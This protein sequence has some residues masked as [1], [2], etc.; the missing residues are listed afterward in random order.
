[1]A[2]S[3]GSSSTEFGLDTGEEII[4]DEE[5]LLSQA[6][7]R[8]WFLAQLRGF[9][10][11]YHLFLALRLHGLL[12]K[13]ALRRALDRIVYR[14]ES[15]RT[16]FTQVDGRPV[17][18]I[19]D[20][21]YCA[22]RL[23]EEDW[24]GKD[25][26]PA[27][28]SRLMKRELQNGFDLERETLI[29][30]RLL[31]VD[32]E[33]H[34][35]LVTLHRLVAD[36]R[37]LSVFQQELGSLYGA[38]RANR[39]DPLPELGLQYADYA[40]WQ[41]QWMGE[42]ALRQQGEYWQA[43]L[44]GAPALLRLPSDHPRPAR[45][46]FAGGLV[47]LEFEPALTDRLR[48]FAQRG[49]IAPQMVLLAAWGALLS[50]LSGQEDLVIGTSVANRR[51][52]T[53]AMIGCFANPLALRIDLSGNPSGSSLVRRLAKHWTEAMLRQ[54]IPFEQV[55]DLLQ[56][57]RSLAHAPL[58]QVM[59]E[60]QDS[61]DEPP[62]LAG[63]R[64]ERCSG[65]L[66]RSVPFDLILRLRAEGARIVGDVAY[67]SALFEQH[68]IGHLVACLHELIGAMLSHPELPLGQLS[69]PMWE[70]H[71]YALR[72]AHRHVTE[73]ALATAGAKETNAGYESPQTPTETAIATIWSRLLQVEHISR[74]DD[75]F[76]LGGR[77]LQIVELVAQLQQ[78]HG[79]NARLEDVFVYPVLVDLAR[80]LEGSSRAML[81]PITRSERGQ[82]IPLS[83]A[84]QRLWFLAQMASGSEAYHVAMGMRL[85]GELDAVALR[86][87]LDRIVARH[88]SL[89]TTFVEV[90]GEPTQRI[91]PAEGSRFHLLEHDLQGDTH[92]KEKV[93][94]LTA[95]EALTPFDLARG[96]LVRGRL[97]KLQE[98]NHILR[99]TMHH[100][101]S[102]GWS[103]GVLRKEFTALYTAFRHG[104]PDPLPALPIQ[105]ADF[106][107]WQRKWM[108]GDVLRRQ[109]EYW[110]TT[111]IG[112]PALL[113]LPADHPRP[114]LQ[115]YRGAVAQL[116]LDE[117]LSAQLKALSRRHGATLFM[118]VLAGLSALFARLSGQHDIV[119]GVPVANRVR[120]ETEGLIGFFA[121]NLA[122]RLNLSGSPSVSELLEHTRT[123]AL[124]AQQNQ[125]IPFEQVVEL[126]QPVR[127][128]GASPLFQVMF[129]WQNIP[130]GNE[131][132]LAGLRPRRLRSSAP[133]VTARF[134]MALSMKEQGNLI[135]GGVEYA[136]SLFEP[137]TI[138]RY[139]G[140]L[141]NLLAAMVTDDAAIVDRLPFIGE[142]ERHL[143]VHTWN[144]TRQEF[145]QVAFMHAPFEAQVRATPA[146]IAVVCGATQL[147]YAGL[148]ARANRLAHY[149]REQ[150]V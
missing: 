24:C 47:E 40:A 148:N 132:P 69:V 112:S 122:L 129:A 57:A 60:W 105:L 34:V 75:F 50:R 39:E 63:L 41:R 59:F 144:D 96:P 79:I 27:E 109:A 106:A 95:E 142:A 92:W 134:D 55:L 52:E 22:F 35:L 104:R 48:H 103:V 58:F 20:P 71:A 91:A 38:F 3:P 84:Q 77:S 51:P 65:S 5:L 116:V 64:V 111:L 123:Q 113:E 99:I 49:G 87:A 100:I 46:R 138:E 9:G 37:S 70:E 29:R 120:M 139:L 26:T 72:G 12:D 74:N 137:A 28:L 131:L 145:A 80:V 36:V 140:Y 78:Q 118:T 73:A 121:N 16:C 68:T 98:H 42:A 43:A 107:V 23:A 135:T 97:I 76:A 21:E 18:R 13:T 81:P 117:A 33:E 2:T 19:A 31:Q 94:A 1:M 85:D 90:D 88:E 149:L 11:T 133:R 17:Q 124:N 136:T 128:L 101:V 10:D 86:R 125:D 143:L 150:G 130:K 147:D 44:A 6:Q 45:Q 126:V 102:D 66:Q 62:A 30:G 83:F 8:L 14:H 4:A 15:L 56:P 25:S 54:D 108:D 119:I 89:R 114:A 93:L 110:K 53:A 32:E 67:A 7:E 141:R 127:N 82:R 61:S 146:A 115:Q